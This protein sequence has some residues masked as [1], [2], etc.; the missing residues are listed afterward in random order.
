MNT[1]SLTAKVNVFLTVII[2]FFLTS[3]SVFL[4]YSEADKKLNNSFTVYSN[5]PGA[6]IYLLHN[7]K[8]ESFTSTNN[9]HSSG[10]YYAENTFSQLKKR[11][12]KLVI[13]KPNY[14]PD[15]IVIKRSPR[16]GVLA[17]DIICFPYLPFDL[18]SHRLYKISKKSKVHHITLSYTDNYI[19][20]KYLE[21]TKNPKLDNVNKFISE[22]SGSKY[23]D[24]VISKKDSLLSIR[25]SLLSRLESALSSN[26]NTEIRIYK[27]EII[28]TKSYASCITDEEI[29]KFSMQLFNKAFQNSKNK[30]TYN[31][32]ISFLDDFVNNAPIF[33]S[34][35]DEEAKKTIDN[36]KRMAIDCLNSEYLKGDIN[37]VA[38]LNKN[39]IKV[40]TEIDNPAFNDSDF[41][42]LVK[43]LK[44]SLNNYNGKVEL[45]GTKI[46]S[47]YFSSELNYYLNKLKTWPKYYDS[48][49]KTSSDDPRVIAELKT[50]NDLLHLQ[51]SVDKEVITFSNGV[52]ATI[53]GFQKEKKV[54][55]LFY[56]ESARKA[57][58]IQIFDKNVDSNN[59]VQNEPK[60]VH[61]Y[62]THYLSSTK[63]GEKMNVYLNLHGEN[64][65]ISDWI[66][67]V[68]SPTRYCDENFA[69]GFR[70]GLSSLEKMEATRGRYGSCASHLSIILLNMNLVVNSVYAYDKYIPN[71]SKLNGAIEIFT[72]HRDE[73]LSQEQELGKK[74]ESQKITFENSENSKTTN[75][76]YEDTYNGEK[77]ELKLYDVLEGEGKV[78]FNRYRRGVLEKTITGYWKEQYVGFGD[79]TNVVI[80]W[81]GANAALGQTKYF[82]RKYASG[83]WQDLQSGE[84]EGKKTWT[85]CNN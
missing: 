77:N 41:E 57:M 80:D 18:L 85:Y 43:I 39:I 50:F 1:I 17:V 79:A 45:S 51:S 10:E 8:K 82:I 19:K 21:L 11:R 13:Y 37:N 5:V 84:F 63:P 28:E 81:D 65:V 23:T 35:L 12:M 67:E 48:D 69:I 34:N 33:F 9:L 47:V 24:N 26:E 56:D 58:L 30:K 55:S 44:T 16:A 46:S 2:L 32:L 76:C 71:V 29:S 72:K 78:V 74:I 3:C 4:P 31:A 40:L 49:T 27:D 42:Y 83:G 15:T 25:A 59:A 53:D 6:G 73:Y 52:I 38:E 62:S 64:E 7:S 70:P 14:I 61:F 36:C 54:F 66:V 60:E 22:F 20:S 75:F 68:K